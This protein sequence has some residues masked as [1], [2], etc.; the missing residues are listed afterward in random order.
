MKKVLIVGSGLSGV[1]VAYQLVQHNVDVTVVDS[2]INHS[3]RI[4]AGMINPLVFRRMTKSWRVDE[5]MPYLKSFYTHLEKEFNQTFFHPIQIRRLFSNDHER[6][7][8]LKKQERE[9]FQPYMNIVSDEDMN[10]SK[11]K[12]P[13]GSGRVK[14]SA[15]VD[16]SLFLDSAKQ[17]LS[18]NATLLNETLD[19]SQLDGISYKGTTYDA[20]VFCEGYQLKENP[21]LKD[22]PLNQTKG[23][24]LVVRANSIPEDESV[25]RKSFMLPMGNK[26]FKIGSTYEWHNNTLHITDEGRKLMLNNLSY[27]T[28]EVVEV[29]NQEAGVRPTT[30]DRRPLIGSHSKIKGYYVFNGL[31][32]KGYMLAPLLSLEFCEYLLNNKELDL[33]VD[34]K[35]CYPGR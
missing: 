12:N 24:T 2:G 8:W 29:I 27:L 35:R 19:Y 1:C 20:I 26:L 32:T 7:L 34:V 30:S 3:S 17:W 28:D 23:Q 5:F 18:T 11:V 21:F 22:L 9:D 13:F 25:N 14:Q 15:F 31:G 6:E 4:A 16:T 10:Y 33:E